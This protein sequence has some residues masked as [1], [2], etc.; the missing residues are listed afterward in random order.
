MKTGLVVSPGAD[1][2]GE[3]RFVDIGLSLPSPSAQVLE[4]VDVQGLLEVPGPRDDK[5]TRGVVGVVA[6]S[7]RYGGAGV[8]CTGAALRGGAGMVRY[9]GTVPDAIRVLKGD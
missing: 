3:V 5:Y 4:S 2:A 1:L 8:L 9:A 6:G 7:A